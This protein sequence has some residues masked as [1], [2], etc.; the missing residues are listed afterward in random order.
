ML[1]TK[2]YKHPMFSAAEDIKEICKPLHALNITYFSHVNIDNQKK[3]S[4][5]AN[6]PSFA[7]HYLKNKYYNADIHLSNE[8]EFGKIILWDSLEKT[9]ETEK[10]DLESQEFGIR[11]TFTL[12]EK[13]KTGSNYYHFSTHINNSAINQVY[14]NNLELLDLFISQFKGQV[15][16]SKKLLS[17]Y[18]FKFKLDD[19]SEGFSYNDKILLHDLN[20]KSATLKNQLILTPNDSECLA[21]FNK[22]TKERLLLAPQQSKCLKL[23]LKGY[24]NKEIGKQLNL[25]YRTVE[26][27]FA[28]IRQMLGCKSSKEMIGTYSNLILN[29]GEEN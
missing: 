28:R 22:E 17:A 11:H 8:K 9:G 13:N 10:M 14:L 2:V 20:L 21:L 7:E 12:V 5:I 24:S 27:Y 29:K 15:N 16:S 19:N 18:D 1:Q 6:N 3:F 23:L 26:H 25:S 4:A